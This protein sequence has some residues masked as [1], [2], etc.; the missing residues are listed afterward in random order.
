MHRAPCLA[1]SYTSLQHRLPLTWHVAHSFRYSTDLY[2][3]SVLEM[4]AAHDAANPLFLYLPWQAVHAPYDDVPH[5]NPG[6]TTYESMLWATDVYAGQIRSLLEN[7]G[8]Y[9][10]TLVVYSADNGGRGDGCNYPL[11]GEKRTSYEVRNV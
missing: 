5:V 4:L 11:R 3:R 9:S 8:M 10:N 7:K 6:K 1:T 2:G